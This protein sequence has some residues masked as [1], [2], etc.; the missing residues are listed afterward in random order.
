MKKLKIF[1][2]LNRDIFYLLK[3]EFIL[4][5][6]SQQNLL[7]FFSAIEIIFVLVVLLETELTAK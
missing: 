6:L 5:C 7:L 3:K 4:S 2:G 1:L